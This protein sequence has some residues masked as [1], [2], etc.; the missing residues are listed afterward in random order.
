MGL[1]LLRALAILPDMYPL[2]TSIAVQMIRFVTARAAEPR[3][4]TAIIEPRMSG[5][6]FIE[7]PCRDGCLRPGDTA[8]ARV[9]QLFLERQSQEVAERINPGVSGR[10]KG[11]ADAHLVRLI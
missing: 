8:Q 9:M 1:A 3:A 2:A 7:P 4:A 11:E 5:S 10:H 6:F